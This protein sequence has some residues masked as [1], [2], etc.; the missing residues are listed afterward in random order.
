MPVSQNQLNLLE[1]LLVLS[2]VDDNKEVKSE[3][4]LTL[5]TEGS[6]SGKKPETIRIVL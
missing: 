6:N 2:E 4:I 5:N 3:Q 1:S